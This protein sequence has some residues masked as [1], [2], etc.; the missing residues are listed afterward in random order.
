[1]L[2]IIHTKVSV[3]LL[4]VFVSPAGLYLNFPLTSIFRLMF[5]PTYKC[6]YHS[7]EALFLQSST[8]EPNNTVLGSSYGSV[9]PTTR[10]RCSHSWLEFLSVPISCSPAFGLHGGVQYCNR[11]VCALKKTMRWLMVYVA[12]YNA[13]PYSSFFHSLNLHNFPQFCTIAHNN[14][15]R[16]LLRSPV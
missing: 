1:M 3:L 5:W 4:Y 7:I 11:K 10:L 16:L 13:F 9:F 15:L 6:F 2:W 8:I 14:R 12:G